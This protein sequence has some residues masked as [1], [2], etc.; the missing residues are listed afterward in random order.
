MKIIDSIALVALALSL[1]SCAT[2]LPP[3][4]FHNSDPT[5]LV[6][7]SLD[8]KTSQ[9]LQPKMSGGDQNEKVLASAQAL[10]RH[11]EAVV[12]LENYTELQVG[13]QFR[14]RSIP[15]FVGLRG[16]GYQRIVFL[17]GNGVANPEG[18]ITLAEY[19]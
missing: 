13:E 11:Q 19:E 2:P 17:Q 12:I 4:A 7:Q 8:V 10:P 14:D 6:I 9:M 15:L 1:T 5:A 16:L 18:L 3:K